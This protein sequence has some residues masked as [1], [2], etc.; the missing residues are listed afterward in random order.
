MVNYDIGGAG[1]ENTTLQYTIQAVFEIRLYRDDNVHDDVRLDVEFAQDSAKGSEEFNVWSAVWTHIPQKMNTEN[2]EIQMNRN[3]SLS[4]DVLNL[5]ADCGYNI[6]F[7]KFKVLPDTD[8]YPIFPEFL[9]HLKIEKVPDDSFVG[10]GELPKCYRV[11]YVNLHGLHVNSV[12]QKT[13][14]QFWMGLSDYIFE[15]VKYEHI[16]TRKLDFP[17]NVPVSLKVTKDALQQK[18]EIERRY[19]AGLYSYSWQ[20]HLAGQRQKESIGKSAQW[21]P[22]MDTFF[23]L[24]RSKDSPD[25]VAWDSG[26]EEFKGRV[27]Q[28]LDIIITAKRMIK[29]GQHVSFDEGEAVVEPWDQI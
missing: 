29:E 27:Q 16:S 26:W 25:G 9:R 22:C 1:S 18:V 19:G 17:A 10:I 7:S 5:D 6:E 24:S 20:H 15:V 28:C 4:I 23:P 2:K 11:S 13:K 21:E 8:I 14:H 3:L 12:T